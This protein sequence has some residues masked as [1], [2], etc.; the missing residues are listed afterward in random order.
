MVLFYTEMWER[1]S[2]YGMRALLTLYLTT[3]LINGGFGLVRADALQI[4]ATF[5]GLVYLTPIIGGYLA[6]KFLGQQKAVYIGAIL[7]A[8]GQFFMAYSEFG[9][10]VLRESNRN[11]GLGLI[12]MGT[13]F[14]KAN[15]STIVGEL[16]EEN[17]ARK[18]SAFT[19]FYM[20]I[21]VG[22]LL[23]P[24]VAG[25]LGQE[26]D[27]AWGFA[28]AG[29]G[30][31]LS[32]IWFYTQRSKLG[33]A[34]LPPRNLA[35]GIH[36]LTGRDGRDIILYI[37]S[38]LLLVWGGLRL[39]GMISSAIQTGFIWA[40]V[41]AGTSVLAWIIIRNTK[42]SK[43]WSNIS[44]IFILAFFNILFWS[45]YEQAGGTFNL[46]AEHQTDRL[47]PF[48]EFPASW[49]QMVPAF[50]IVAFASLF[51]MLWVWLNKRKK[52][53]RTPVKFAIGLMLMSVGFVIMNLAAGRAGQAG[54][55]SP[56]WLLGVYFMHT[57]GELCLSPIGLSM[58]TKLSPRP[59]VSVMMG[60]WFGSIALANY[61]AGVLESILHN[62]FPQMRLYSFLTFTTL[63]AGIVLLLIS[64]LLNRLMK[65][66]H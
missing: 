38:I 40:L 62:Y 59:I 2:Y 49:F 4:Y 44:V 5:T 48:G 64:P 29:V 30:M 14:F 43:A 42:G 45:G 1:F 61:L 13:G 12:I 8:I 63:G 16:Y 53:P 32:A 52:E 21:N 23:G 46:F 19:I 18:D 24:F 26:I 55:V 28:S 25:F 41:V 65:D 10:M 9:E 20:G 17:D 58:V 35:A 60:I 56:F 47:T 15:I 11:L 6:D 37:G 3:E 27:W 57:M 36:R 54:A 50:Y 33:T 22:A 66:I 34:G 51:A 31:I 39:W 7:M